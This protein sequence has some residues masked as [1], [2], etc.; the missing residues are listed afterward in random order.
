MIIGRRVQ[1][2]ELVVIE[3]AHI[4]KTMLKRTQRDKI[5]REMQ[6]EKEMKK[7]KKWERK[8]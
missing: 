3:M 7:R 4:P 6:R 8:G 5:K 2:V 1:H